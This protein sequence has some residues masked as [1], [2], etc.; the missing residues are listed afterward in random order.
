MR[1]DFCGQ[2]KLDDYMAEETAGSEVVLGEIPKGQRVHA[3]M[4]CSHETSNSRTVVYADEEV[5]WHRLLCSLQDFSWAYAL[6]LPPAAPESAPRMKMA[7]GSF[8]LDLLL[9][10]Y[11]LADPFASAFRCGHLAI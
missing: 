6:W 2:E 10:E 7:D 1:L 4:A 3:L 9:M 11:L 8:K 5:K